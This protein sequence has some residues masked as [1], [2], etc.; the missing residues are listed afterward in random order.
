MLPVRGCGSAA[1]QKVA[2]RRLSRNLL[3]THEI[4]RDNRVWHSG[5]PWFG[6]RSQ[7]GFQGVLGRIPAAIS[8]RLN[9]RH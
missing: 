2:G 6:L 9:G 7:R 8:L 4:W 3:I 1:I 5:C